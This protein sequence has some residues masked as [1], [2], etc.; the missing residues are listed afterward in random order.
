MPH[1]ARSCAP[2]LHS[3]RSPSTPDG[4]SIVYV[5]RRVRGDDYV[6]HLW[7]RPWRGGRARQLTR[8]RVR[9]GSA[10]I[11]PDGEPRRLHSHARRGRTT[12]SPQVWLL[13]L[14][15]GEPYQVTSL[16]HGVGSAHWS[17]DGDRLLLVAQAGDHRFVVGEERKGRA[18]LARR[19]T[20]L[21]FRDDD[22]GH[23]VRRSHLWVVAP[24]AG[25]APRQL[26]S[27]D[28]DVLTPTWPP[29]GRRIAFA[30]D[31]GPDANVHPR[32]QIWWVDAD[33][34][35]QRIRELVSLAGDADE[36]SVSPDGKRLAFI[37]TDVDD[38]AD[39]VPPSVWVM[40]LP[41]GTPRNLTAALDRPVGDWAW[42]DLLMC[43]EM[44]G[45]VWL[46][47]GSLATVIGTE[48]RNLP[49]QVDLDGTATPL[50]DPTLPVAVCAIQVAAGRI[51][52][53]AA[54][55]GRAGEVWALEAGR[56]R[57]VTREGSAWQRRFPAVETRERRPGSRRCDPRLARLSGGRR[58]RRA[59]DRPAHS[60]R[61]DGLLGTRWNARPDVA[62]RRRLPG[63]DAEHS[64]V[65][66]VWRR[67]GEGT[68]R[69]VGRG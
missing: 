61:A 69:T 13:P 22:S 1:P 14:D 10:A 38:P 41:N 65:D 26:T 54:E 27:G 63:A 12:P 37:G 5:L 50:L 9:D 53:G 68:L 39:H 23:V 51:A 28:F 36:P 34:G 59:A 55:A 30:A 62:V 64:R 42:S 24:R 11:A 66:D 19:M 58:A 47:D 15:G 35:R 49:Y 57:Q 20:R 33:A 46:D 29:D 21:D 2:R 56:M 60:R 16:E 40:D 7:T 32:T 45:P 48:G 18:P 31:R 25:A 43:D 3:S 8:G 4:A 67:M 17:P 6:S 52:V 44:P